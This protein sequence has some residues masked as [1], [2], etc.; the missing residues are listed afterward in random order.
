MEFSSEQGLTIDCSRDVNQR[1]VVRSIW[2]H[3]TWEVLGLFLGK[4]S[5]ADPQISTQVV[6]SH[7][8]FREGRCA[9]ASRGALLGWKKIRLQL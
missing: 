7:P 8:L 4:L 3:G 5:K 9:S 2:E 1:V 6:G